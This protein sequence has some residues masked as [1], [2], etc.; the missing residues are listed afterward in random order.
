MVR[1]NISRLPLACSVP[2]SA[3][4]PL[5]A[6]PPSGQRAGCISP[7][8]SASPTV[9][10]PSKQTTTT[11]LCS[12]C[13][14]INVT[15]FSTSRRNASRSPDW[16]RSN[17]RRMLFEMSLFLSVRGE[18]LWRMGTLRPLHPAGPSCSPLWQLV[19][20]RCGTA[21]QSRGQPCQSDVKAK[22]RG[23]VHSPH[24]RTESTFHP[25]FSNPSALC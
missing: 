20:P 7:A 24:S 12:L 1:R 5:S 16:C 3:Q 25:L 23:T 14:R 6:P 4:S 11:T 21:G 10:A 2:P 13:D 9:S 18:M 22:C 15:T 17:S 19:S 8:A